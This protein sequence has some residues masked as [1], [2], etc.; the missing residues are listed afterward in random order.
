MFDL[1]P[2]GRRDAVGLAGHVHPV[3]FYY[4]AHLL[5]QAGCRRL[6]VHFDL[7]KKSGV[8]FAALFFP[9]IQR[10]HLGFCCCM[11]RK[12]PE[13][14]RE[15]A[16]LLEEINSWGMLTSRTVIVEAFE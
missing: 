15:N 6:V 10:W 9:F 13:L 12:Y 16:P 1:L 2:L 11:R 3:G 7:R 5:R 14:S 4:L 8:I